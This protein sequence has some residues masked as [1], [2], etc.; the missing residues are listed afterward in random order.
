MKKYPVVI[1]DGLKDCG[2]CSLL[3]IMKKY[4]GGASK[5]Y[6]RELTK[7][8]KDGVNAYSLIDAAKKL[9]FSASGVTGSVEQLNNDL[10]PCI[11]HVII[12]KKYKHFIVIY[13][14]N[15]NKK[16]LLIADPAKGLKT[17][18]F[19]E[20]NQI[21]TNNYILLKPNKKIQNISCNNILI[22]NILTFIK[23]LKKPLIYI[24]IMSLI[25]TFL[26][27][28]LSFNFKFIIDYAIN[29]SSKYNIYAISIALMIL[30]VIKEISSYF[31]NL[32][33][34][35]INHQL[36][37]ELITDTFNHIL[38]LPYLYFKNRT[39]GEITS[40][41]QDINSIK[42]VISKLFMTIFIDS[43]LVIF[44][45]ITLFKINSTLTWIAISLVIIYI[46][47]LFIFR[48]ILHKKIIESKETSAIVNSYLVESINGL[49]TI[50]SLNKKRAFN[51]RLKEKYF[52]YIKVSN[53]TNNIFLLETFLK[54]LIQSLGI[55]LL[56]TIGSIFVI[57]NQ[58][59]LADLIT[60][61]SLI[62]YFL[63]PIRNIIDSD[64]IF[65][66]AIV[67]FK[68]INELYE[69][70]EEKTNN[71]T[72]QILKGNIKISNLTYSYNG[73]NN[74]LNN[75]NLEIKN[76]EKILLYGQSGNGKST[77]ARILMKYI[78]INNGYVS[79]EGKDINKYNLSDLRNN[80]CHV[81]QNEIVFTDSIYNNVILD[82]ENFQKYNEISNLCL[83][84][85]VY[86]NNIL[87]YDMLLEE[88]GFNISGGE[89]QR[90][91][92][93]RA[94]YQNKNIYIL[95]ESLSEVDIHKEREIL[96]NI[97]NNYKD[98]TF[99]VISHR[100][101]NND[102]FDRKIEIKNGV[103]YEQ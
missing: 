19:K 92:L 103:C 60:Y 22:S 63:E 33:L 36:D 68:R 86:K 31:R 96:K 37:F 69:I 30:I 17:I 3:M 42:E 14:I 8:T 21:T 53:D 52:N 5:E 24:I 59:T 2:V 23:K 84:K 55:M 70:E 89:R 48:K 25:Y 101:D 76:G 87:A 9:N 28:F 10:L 88:D 4:G 65:R 61:N 58:L 90:I 7:T 71:E 77:I 1:Q 20:F 38:S 46:V 32:L 47:I 54:E 13:K 41:I 27:I 50:K 39:T 29:Y 78:N 16:T 75:C 34:N 56:I 57:N 43:I 74:I 98:K 79:I 40:R 66:E 93:A 97:F 94:L 26:N 99:I 35:N 12:D 72:G 67:S 64:I 45:F 62:F 83:L 44:V 18:T 82:E 102:L 81:S 51:I 85:E 95:D 73:K 6:L 15:K 11:A 91:I 80:I 49:E 100:F